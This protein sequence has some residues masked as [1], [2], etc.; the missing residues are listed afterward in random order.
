MNIYIGSDH[1]GYNLKKYILDEFKNELLELNGGEYIINQINLV[2]SF[3]LDG[4]R[5][6]YPDIAALAGKATL[7]NSRVKYVATWHCGVWFW[8]RN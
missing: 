5:C 3:C 7:N 2:D 6:D 1:G 8:Y 4:E